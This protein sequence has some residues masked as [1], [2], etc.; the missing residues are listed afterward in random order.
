MLIFEI[1]A[2]FDEEM[3]LT[4][5]LLIII[6]DEKLIRIRSRLSWRDMEFV[7]FSRA[8]HNN[9]YAGFVDR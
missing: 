8:E 7:V 6:P 3:A 4:R 1:S 5:Q 2:E 9:I